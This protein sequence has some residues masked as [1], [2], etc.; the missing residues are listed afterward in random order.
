[1]TGKINLCAGIAAPRLQ[2]MRQSGALKDV[3][4]AAKI[5]VLAE[6]AVFPCRAQAEI[7]VKL[8]PN[9]NQ[10]KN[11]PIFATGFLWMKNIVFK[12]QDNLRQKIKQQLQGRHLIIFLNSYEQK[13]QQH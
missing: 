8:T 10:T 12:V 6:I 13:K 7:A 4:I 2:K 11:V 9:I 5:C 1:M 3:R